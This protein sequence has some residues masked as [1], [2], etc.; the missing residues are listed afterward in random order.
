MSNK[1]K[2]V[3]PPKTLLKSML[4]E[5]D[6]SNTRSQVRN[7][8]STFLIFMNDI[9]KKNYQKKHFLKILKRLLKK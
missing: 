8:K 9:I 7:L 6:N 4:E 3:K 2:E 1:T 5:I